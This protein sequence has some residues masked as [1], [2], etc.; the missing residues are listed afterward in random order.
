MGIEKK[1]TVERVKLLMEELGIKVKDRKVVE[2][3]RRSA[4]E[5][6]ECGKGN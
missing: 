6:E 2:I 5:A 4:G 3:S 1:E